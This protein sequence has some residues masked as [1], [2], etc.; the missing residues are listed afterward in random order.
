MTCRHAGTAPFTL[1]VPF[2]I[3]MSVG[4]AGGSEMFGDG[5]GFGEG[6]VILNLFDA[7]GNPVTVLAP[8]TVPEP[9]QLGFAGPLMLGAAMITRRYVQNRRHRT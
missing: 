1:G 2:E 9:G 3:S 5:G 4:G 6:E 8:V 7:S